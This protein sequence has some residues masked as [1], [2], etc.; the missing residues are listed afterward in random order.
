MI[1][2]PVEA[3][4]DAIGRSDWAAAEALL[5]DHETQ[6]RAAFESA[7]STAAR[8]RSAWLDLLAAQRALIQ[9]LSAA[10]DEAARAME[11]LGHD[12]RAVNAYLDGAR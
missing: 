12:R 6:L 3:I 11:R 1:A 4:H 9:H 7:P 8:D 10:R 5:A 2:L